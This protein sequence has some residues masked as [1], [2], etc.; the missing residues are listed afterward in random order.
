MYLHSEGNDVEMLELSI[1][2]AKKLVDLGA[3]CQRLATNAD[4]K[5][6]ILEGYFVEE[7]A[8]LALLSSDPNLS[9]EIRNHVYRDLAGP[10]A[11]KRHL[12]TI[13]QRGRIAAEEILDHQETLEDMREEGDV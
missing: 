1:E 4:F 13:V 5:K 7:A 12:H 10:G 6:I 11:L 3:A 8:R 9:E 2:E